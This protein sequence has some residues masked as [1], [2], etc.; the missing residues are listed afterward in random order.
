ML[1]GGTSTD[2]QQALVDVKMKL[3]EAGA[4]PFIIA[5]GSGHDFSKL[6][7]TVNDPKDIFKAP[8]FQELLFQVK[9][10]AEGVASRKSKLTNNLYKNKIT[11]LHVEGD[12]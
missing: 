7:A 10:T 2:N 1:T 4:L 6:T 12:R 11:I 5:V 9:S 3:R 8:S